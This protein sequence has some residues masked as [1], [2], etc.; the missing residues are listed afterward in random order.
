MVPARCIASSTSRQGGIGQFGDLVL[1]RIGP[2]SA[3]V[4]TATQEGCDMRASE[5][6]H[7]PAVTCRTDATVAQVARLVR[8][9]HLE[10]PERL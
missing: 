7:A 3:I 6:M 1:W 10:R 2:A 5:L 4:G 9:G 8:N